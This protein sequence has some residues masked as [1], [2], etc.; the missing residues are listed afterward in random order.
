MCDINKKKIKDKGGV[1]RIKRT[2]VTE[3]YNG[4]E[5]TRRATLCAIKFSGKY[6]VGET[7]CSNDDNFVRRTGT[8]IAIGR[9]IQNYEREKATSI[10]D[11]DAY[12]L[13]KEDLQ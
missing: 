8:D 9:A 13:M 5:I 2:N 4:E 7:Q 6:Y 10:Q 3:I 12:L 1:F 11:V